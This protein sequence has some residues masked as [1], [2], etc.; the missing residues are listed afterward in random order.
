MIWQCRLHTQKVVHCNW[1][2]HSVVAGRLQPEKDFE[3]KSKF[4]YKRSLH[5]TATDYSKINFPSHTNC[6]RS[7]QADGVQRRFVHLR[8][9][10]IQAVVAMGA[11]VVNTNKRYIDKESMRLGTFVEC[12]YQ[13]GP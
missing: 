1:I 3:I 6:D 13:T 7:Q 10:M 4:T 12:A 2:H 5:L 9:T 8:H 11:T